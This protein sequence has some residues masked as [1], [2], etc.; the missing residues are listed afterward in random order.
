M[1]PNW[2]WDDSPVE[3]K[4]KQ[5][6][7]ILEEVSKERIFQDVKWG[8][9]N[10]PDGT[11]EEYETSATNYRLSCALKADAGTVTWLDLLHEKTWEAFAT[12]SP[13]NLRRELLQVAAVAIAWI[14]AID[15]RKGVS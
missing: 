15:R 6:L 4:R 8:E 7:R 13:C 3:V 12:S 2:K 11:S 10:H 14:E 9:Q 1:V 5:T